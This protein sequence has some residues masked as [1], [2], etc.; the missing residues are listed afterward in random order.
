MKRINDLI[1]VV[2]NFV[3]KHTC[4]QLYEYLTN[5]VTH[6]IADEHNM[7]WELGNNI[8]YSDIKDTYIKEKVYDIKFGVA[9]LLSYL[10][11]TKVYP[12]FTDMVLWQKHQQMNRHVDN[13]SNQVGR[14]DLAMRKYSAI[15]Y[16]NDNY[17][18]GKTFVSLDEEN[19]YISKPKTGTLLMF[20]SDQ[21]TTHGVKKVKVG[22]R[23]TLAM[24]FATEKKYQEKD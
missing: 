13:G 15:I 20:T 14:D 8:F 6:N 18:G 7:P 22:Y 16:L 10:H 21:R 23:G 19:D 2:N 1:F 24:W 4:H 3:T 5:T 17:K 11:N 12:H 9:N